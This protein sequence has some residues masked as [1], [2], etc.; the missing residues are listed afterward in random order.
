MLQMHGGGDG[1]GGGGGTRGAPDPSG[2]FIHTVPESSKSRWSHIDDLDSF[3]KKVYSY[4]QKHGFKV[5]MLQVRKATCLFAAAL[6]LAMWIKRCSD[7]DLILVPYHQLSLISH[8]VACS[9]K[10]RKW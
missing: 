1:L 2:V 5:M 9:K 10:R 3:F 7:R 4:H 6:S 8:S